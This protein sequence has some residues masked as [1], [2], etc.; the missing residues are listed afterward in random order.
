MLGEKSDTRIILADSHGD[1]KFL[2]SYG[3]TDSHRRD[4]GTVKRTGRGTHS[5]HG[6]L[7]RKLIIRRC[8][9]KNA[10]QKC[11]RVTCK[12]SRGRN[13]LVREKKKPPASSRRSFCSS[14]IK[15]S[16]FLYEREITVNFLQYIHEIRHCIVCIFGDII[17]INLQFSLFRIY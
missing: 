1:R 11:I 9:K 2:A 12:S 3:P 13:R 15:A 17:L 7:I 6:A 4:R 14:V 16:Y 5:M 10:A 8:R